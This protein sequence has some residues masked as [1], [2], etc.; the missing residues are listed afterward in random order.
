[1]S[2]DRRLFFLFHHA[3]RALASHANDQVQDALG[4]SL[5]QLGTLFHVDQHPG[6]TLVDIATVLDLQKSAVTAIVRRLERARVIRREVHPT[7]GRSSILF[8]TA[9]GH[10]TAAKAGPV[11]QRL[12][13]GVLDGFAQRDVAVIYRFL[14][15]VLGRFSRE[16]AAAGEA[17]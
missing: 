6:C 2:T 4:I 9:R 16:A 7:D 14:H 17:A 8:A 1:V 5:V 11:L 12:T 15:S 3:N 10:A 13:A